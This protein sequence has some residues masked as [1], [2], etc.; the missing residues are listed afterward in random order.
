MKA[1]LTR[2]TFDPLKHFARVLMQQGR[3]QLDA[4][5]DEQAAI[6]SYYLEKLAA[7]LIG[8]AGGPASNPGFAISPITG[9]TAADFQIGFGDYYVDGLLCQADFVPLAIFPTSTTNVFQVMNWSTD[10]E[11]PT[12]PYF[13]V[14]DDTLGSNASVQVLIN[15]VKGVQNQIT[16]MQTNKSPIP[17]YANPKLRRWIT[18]LHQP[19]YVFST[20]AGAISPPP[21]TPNGDFQIYLD[22]WERVIT[23]AEDDSIRE[24]ALGGPDTA[25]R[26]KRVWQVKWCPALNPEHDLTQQLYQ[27][28]QPANRGWLEAMAKQGSQSTDPCIINPN[29]SYT[30]PEN[31]LYRVEINRFGQAWSGTDPTNTTAATFKWSREN[32]SVFFPIVSG[33][34]TPTVVVESLGRDDRF[35]LSEGD[36]VEVQDDRSVLLNSVGNLLRVQ[37]VDPA[38]RTVTLTGTVDPVLGSDPRL[39]PLLRRWDQTAGDPAEGGLTLANDNAAFV[40]ENVW[41]ALEDGVQIRFQLASSASPPPGTQT[42]NQYRTGDYWLIPARTA[43]GD[44]EWPKV[45]GLDGNPETDPQGNPI[46]IAMPPHG[47]AHHYAPLAIV[48]VGSSGVAPKTTECRSSFALP[49]TKM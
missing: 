22:V 2:N 9:S 23:Y 12:I 1:D 49:V 41:L 34:G 24:V 42:A 40:Q 7:D 13:E 38:T 16:V 28:F 3:V 47:V 21:L 39:H 48:S 36:L 43:T 10:F 46:P 35:G 37:S 33:G 30:G 8:P 27:Q 32:G 44:V 11:L 45:L 19:D 20:Q 14:F 25:V 6:L 26:S 5:W 18:Y 15:P 4:D 29:A 31:Q 17:S